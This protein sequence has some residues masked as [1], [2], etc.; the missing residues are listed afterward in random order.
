ML[1]LDGLVNGVF[2]A[3]GQA[4]VAGSRAFVQAEVFDEVLEGLIERCRASSIGSP[5]DDKSD[6]GPLCFDAHRTHVESLVRSGTDEGA[7]LR[8]GGRRP[9]GLARGYYFEPT[10]F[11]GVSREMSIVSQEVFGPVL[12]LS[13]FESEDEVV[14]MA[15]D[16]EFGLA[17]GIWTKDVARAHR[18]AAVLDAGIVWIN[19]YRASTPLSPM[20]GFKSSGWGKEGGTVGIEEFLRAKTV[21][22]S[23]A[24]NTGRQVWFGGVPASWLTASGTRPCGT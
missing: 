20:G 21:S 16:T 23:T 8:Y 4:C 6:L 2:K 1:V 13:R 12:T 10:I 11:T 3:T 22:L 14:K 24:S 9:E 7:D 5:L 18:V 17:A 15:N 19:Q